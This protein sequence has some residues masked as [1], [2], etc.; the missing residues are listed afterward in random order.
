MNSSVFSMP[1]SSTRRLSR[2]VPRVAVPSTCVSPRV[3]TAEPWAVGSTPV[4]I[5]MGRTVRGSRPS[6]RRPSS[7]T[8]RRISAAS[9]LPNAPFSCAMRSLA[10]SASAS[11]TRS[12]IR[13]SRRA[14]T[15]TARSCLP[16][17]SSASRSPAARAAAVRSATSSARTSTTGSNAFFGWPTSARIRS[18][19]A[20]TG[21]NACCAASMAPTMTSSGSSSAAAST[22]RTASREAATVSSRRLA[23][24][25]SCWKVG[26]TT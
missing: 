9:A 5:Q 13:R 15:A 7:T 11:G 24:S 6:V 2:P 4:S 25:A 17:V 19:R 23:G 1:R 3:N 12:A 10:P 22:M 26:A 14:F 20:T 21:A 8:M 18:I 16:T